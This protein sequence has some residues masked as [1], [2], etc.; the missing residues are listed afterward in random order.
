MKIVTLTL[1]RNIS[2]GASKRET[3]IDDQIKALHVISNTLFILDDIN[4]HTQ[5]IV[6]FFHDV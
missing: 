2:W 5:K 1:K 3:S 6:F 4:R